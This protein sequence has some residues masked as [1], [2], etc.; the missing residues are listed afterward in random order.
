M[1]KTYL[2]VAYS[3]LVEADKWLIDPIEGDPRPVVPEEYKLPVLEYLSWG[4][5]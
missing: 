3:I 1:I 2:V 4:G 5:I